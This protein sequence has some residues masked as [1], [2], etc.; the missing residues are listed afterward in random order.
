MALATWPITLPQ[1]VD[2]EGF[3]HSFS[4]S[5]RR[6]EMDSGVP[7]QRPLYTFVPPKFTGQILLDYSQLETL[8]VFWE[9]TLAFG[10]QKFNWVNPLNDQPAVCRFVSTEPPSISSQGGGT[11]IATLN[12]E[13]MKNESD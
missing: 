13:V 6:T 9:D 5:S 3:E 2:H 4:V 12:F 7:F 11:F 1:V 10:T 8:R